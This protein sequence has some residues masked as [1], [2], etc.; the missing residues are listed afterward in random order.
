[1]F[2][3]EKKI[4]EWIVTGDNY[5]FGKNGKEEDNAQA[6]YFYQK[7]AEKMKCRYA[8]YAQYR[9]GECYEFGRGVE[10]NPSRAFSR[11]SQA[12][13]AGK[14]SILR[15]RLAM[16]FCYNFGFGVTQS[17]EE[18][19][20]WFDMAGWSIFDNT[21]YTKKGG[22]PRDYYKRGKA[23]KSG[24]RVKQDLK[25]AFKCFLKAAKY[26]KDAMYELAL[27][28]ASGSGTE[29]N[30]IEANSWM[31]KAAAEDVAEAKTWLTENKDT[32][33][34]AKQEKAKADEAKRIADEQARHEAA[35]QAEKERVKAE[36]AT[37]EKAQEAAKTE[38]IKEQQLSEVDELIEKGILSIE[39]NEHEIGLELIERAA[40]RGSLEAQWLFYIFSLDTD[41][42]IKDWTKLNHRAHFWLAEA[43]ESGHKDAWDLATNGHTLMLNAAF[44]KQE[45]EDFVKK[46]KVANDD[47]KASYWQKIIYTRFNAK[48]SFLHRTKVITASE[49]ARK[50]VMDDKDM[51]ILEQLAKKR[52]EEERQRQIARANSRRSSYINTSSSSS[53]SGKSKEPT[54]QEQEHLRRSWRAQGHDR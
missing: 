5:Y 27:L 26:D 52:Q 42:R 14:N 10:M 47:E 15:A 53:S 38:K 45:L 1:M 37:A 51:E 49:A 3:S 54:M 32:V 17:N 33:N 16:A 39:N 18:S 41:G 40:M 43:A 29:K 50:E 13:D 21:E 23:A 30:L 28:Y 31:E 8:P 35:K 25:F 9:L 7:A 2:E 34:I 4:R 24:K 44:K 6:F 11:Y 20:K 36:I 48:G 22:L 19:E 46:Y 12:A